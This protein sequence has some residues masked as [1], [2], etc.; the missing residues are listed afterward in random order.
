MKYDNLFID[1]LNRIHDANTYKYETAFT[2]PQA[3]EVTVN[4]KRVVMMASN[5]Y[6]GMSNHPVVKK[7]AIDAI[8]EYG[9][10]MASVRFLCG[11]QTIHLELE[12]KISKFI[13][14]EDT[15]LFS[16]AFAANNAF[17]PSLLNEKLGFETYRDVIYTD[18]L[19]H[20]SIIDGMRLCKTETTDKKIYKN[21]DLAQLEQLLEADTNAGYRF[22]IIATDGVFSMEGS[23]AQIDRLVGLAEK[24]QAILFVDDCHAI[25]VVGK[26]GRGTP[27][28]FG[29][30]KKVDVLTGTL[31][32]AIGGA[33]GGYVSGSRKMVE[34]LRQKARPYTFSNS[35]PPSVVMASIAAFDLLTK[36]RSIVTRLHNNT[37]YFRKEIAALGFTILEGDHPIVPV[38]LGEASTAQEMSKAL[39]KA[40]VYVKGLWF[41]VVP[42]GEARLRVQISAALS[43]KN[44]D[45]AL[46]AFEAV[47]KKMK[48]I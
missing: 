27:E 4:G 8:K 31:G 17:F 13:G 42:K 6:L 36:D 23:Y 5:N 19:N 29:V 40:G 38:M 14:T 15:I 18:G 34:Y 24:Y 35:L 45:H 2:T 11:T 47:G 20:A 39:L 25:G 9:Y 44:L 43:K 41:P 1:E 12:K 22:K 30:L 7:A 26:S 3:G 33:L 37:A 48:I 28:K 10:G 16:S 32:K 46:N 21:N